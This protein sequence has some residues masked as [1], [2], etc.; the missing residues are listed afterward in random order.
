MDQ[1]HIDLLDIEVEKMKKAYESGKIKEYMDTY[2]LHNEYHLTRL[3]DAEVGINLDTEFCTLYV[4]SRNTDDVYRYP[5]PMD[6]DIMN[7]IRK[8]RKQKPK[9]KLTEWIWGD[10]LREH[11]LE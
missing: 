9:E 3:E 11:G 5:H 2:T 1:K 8:T 4:I 10:Y 7:A 6:L